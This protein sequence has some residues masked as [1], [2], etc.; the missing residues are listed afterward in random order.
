VQKEVD[1]VQRTVYTS[2]V[3]FHIIQMSYYV[4]LD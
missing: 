2:I 1:S 3:A 4:N